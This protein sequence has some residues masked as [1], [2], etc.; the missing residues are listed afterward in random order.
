MVLQAAIFWSIKLLQSNY[1]TFSFILDQK[2]PLMKW[3]IYIYNMF[4]PLVFCLLAYLYTKDDKKYFN[5]CIAGIVGYLICDVIFLCYPTIMDYPRDVIVHNFTDLVLKITYVAD[6]PALNCFP[7]IHCLFCFQTIY[8]LVSSKKID[9]NV[10]IFGTIGLVLIAISTLTVK[11]HYFYD[12]VASLVVCI[13]ANI[14]TIKFNLQDKI[15]KLQKK[16]HNK[17]KNK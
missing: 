11:Q 8:S 2:I 9:K 7:S 1:H 6:T 5:A 3:T 4:Y 15:R 17:K 12:M 16:N 10:K 13:I 14:I